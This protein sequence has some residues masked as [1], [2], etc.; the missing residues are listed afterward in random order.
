VYSAPIL[1]TNDVLAINRNAPNPNA[2]A[3]FADWTLTPE[4]QQYLAT[5]LR[6]PVALKHPYL[7]E[8]VA[9]VDNVDP[10]REVMERLLG[11]WRRYVEKNR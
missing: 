10:P 9:L 1:A 3:L 7:P 5:G 6:G 4:S 8:G 11:Y 2:A